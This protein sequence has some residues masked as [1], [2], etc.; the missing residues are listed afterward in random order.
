MANAS[1]FAAF[2]RMWQHILLKF[3]GKEPKIYKQS[4]EPVDAPDGSLWIDLDEE[5]AAA[6][7]YQTYVQEVDDLLGGES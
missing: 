3:E 5:S 6:A 2:E 7:L 1:I 4:D